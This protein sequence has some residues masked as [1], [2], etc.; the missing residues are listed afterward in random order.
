[1]SATSIASSGAALRW[2]DQCASI[3]PTRSITT[4]L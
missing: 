2:R 1:M 3:R 4:A